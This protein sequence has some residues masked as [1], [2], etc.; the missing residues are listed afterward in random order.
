MSLTEQCKLTKQICALFISKY[1]LQVV[2]L[3][4][5]VVHIPVMWL[6]YQICIQIALKATSYC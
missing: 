1:T 3:H 6:N 2:V 5:L 4:V